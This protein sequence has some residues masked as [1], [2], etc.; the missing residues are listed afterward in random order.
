V[1]AVVEGHPLHD[2]ADERA[3]AA[4]ALVRAQHAVVVLDEPELDRSPELLGVDRI[5]AMPVRR[6]PD[7]SLDDIQVVGQ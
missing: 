3:K 1:D 5:E 4:A 7:G 6:K 2:H